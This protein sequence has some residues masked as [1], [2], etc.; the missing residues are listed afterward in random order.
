MTIVPNVADM[1]HFN[2]VNF[3][4]IAKA[5]IWGVIHKARQGI[6]YGDPM[7]ARRMAAAKGAGLLWG[8]YD[9]ATGDDPVSNAATFLA[10]ADLG[11]RDLAVLDFED[12]TQSQMSA[13]QAYAFLDEVM[14]RTG[15]ACCI[16]GGNRIREQIRADDPKWIDMAKVVRLWQ[17]RYVRLRPADNAGLFRIID[18]IPPW[19]GNFLIQYTGD[20]AGPQPHTVKGLQ[21][22]ADLNAFNGTR[23]ELAK[24]WSGAPLAG[25]A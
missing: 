7:Y 13:A 2:P 17:C 10:Y 3:S 23:D 19:T 12:N 11:A 15:R 4:D 5:G 22:G 18:P 25:T 20:G 16:Y 21:S 14:Q 24:A 9:F 8:A 6:G 1:A